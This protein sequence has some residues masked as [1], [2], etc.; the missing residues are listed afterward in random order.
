MI[1][2]AM[3]NDPSKELK[4]MQQAQVTRLKGGTFDASATRSNLMRNVRSLAMN[5]GEETKS[6]LAVSMIKLSDISGL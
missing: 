2:A 3:E 1:D 4:R 5:A 6:D